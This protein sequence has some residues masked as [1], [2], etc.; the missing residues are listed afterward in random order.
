MRTADEW[1]EA[2]GE[3]HQ[4]PTN[5]NIHWVCVPLIVFSTIGLLWSIPH[6]YFEGILP[7]SLPHRV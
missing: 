5:K 2:Y 1:F 6:G 7:S 3:S 4:N